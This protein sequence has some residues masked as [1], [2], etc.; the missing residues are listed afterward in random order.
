[1]PKPGHR[2]RTL[3]RVFKKTPGGKVVIHYRERRPKKA[4]CA[5]CGSVLNIPSERPYKMQ[6]MSKSRKK[7]SRPFPELCSRCMRKK[8]KE[9][10]RK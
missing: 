8:I 10:A 6:K 2:S 1:M 9:E 3:R 4:K 7:V 5:S